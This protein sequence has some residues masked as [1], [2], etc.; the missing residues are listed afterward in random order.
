[1]A[2]EGGEKVRLRGRAGGGDGQD[3]PRSAEGDGPRLRVWIL[4]WERLLGA[5]SA[6]QDLAA[7]AG[8]DL[9]WLCPARALVGDRR[10][11]SRRAEPAAADAGERRA[12]AELEHERHD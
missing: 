9:G 2:A 8:Q 12:A 3:C 10:P 4:H 7:D 6:V 1:S 11:D 5:R